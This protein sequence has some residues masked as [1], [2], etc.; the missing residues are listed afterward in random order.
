MALTSIPKPKREPLSD[1]AIVYLKTKLR[2]EDL[3]NQTSSDIALINFARAI[4]Q[5]HNIET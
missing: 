2:K 3:I 1:E 5:A 4:E